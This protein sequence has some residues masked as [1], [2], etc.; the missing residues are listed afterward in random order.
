[1]TAFREFTLSQPTRQ[2]TFSFGGQI[3]QNQTNAFLTNYRR[4]GATSRIAS[5]GCSLKLVAKYKLVLTQTSP[6]KCGT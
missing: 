2:L 4:P 5:L 3:W 6:R 1:M